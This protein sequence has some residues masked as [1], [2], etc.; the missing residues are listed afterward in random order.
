MFTSHLSAPHLYH[1]TLPG[2]CRGSFPSGSNLT[3]L[4]K[5]LL[6]GGKQEWEAGRK[7]VALVS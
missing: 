5:L 3:N 4:T 7:D 6:P 1:C 2:V